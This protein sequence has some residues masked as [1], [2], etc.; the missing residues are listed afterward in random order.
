MKNRSTPES[1]TDP[2]TLV[3]LAGLYDI[4]GE[5]IKENSRDIFADYVLEN[6]SLSE[7][8]EDRGISRQGVYDSVVRTAKKLEEFEEKLG[9]HDRFEKIETELSAAED[10]LEK[11]EEAMTDSDSATQEQTKLLKQ[12]KISIKN[13]RDFM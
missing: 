5:L 12:M 6:L 9:L 10:K 13:I 4:Y 1:L 3:K 11:L 8:A 2:Q 7:I